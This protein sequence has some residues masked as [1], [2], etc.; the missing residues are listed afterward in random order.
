MDS[1]D[2][3]DS[4]RRIGHI[5]WRLTNKRLPSTIYLLERRLLCVSFICCFDSAWNITYFTSCEN[6]PFYSSC[7]YPVK[8]Q[9]G[10]SHC[11]EKKFHLKEIFKK[12]YHAFSNKQIKQS[13]FQTLTMVQTST[14]KAERRGEEEDPVPCESEDPKCVNTVPAHLRSPPRTHS[15]LSGDSLQTRFHSVIPLPVT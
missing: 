3:S 7:H 13:R 11:S 12:R 1:N 5:S 14:G 2:H 8:C 15:P 6:S 4:S 10:N 9:T